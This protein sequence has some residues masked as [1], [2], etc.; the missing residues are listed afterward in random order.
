[1]FGSTIID[2]G[3]KTTTKVSCQFYDLVVTNQG[4][5]CLKSF[6]SLRELNFIC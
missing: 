5:L 4:Q 2:C 3:M 6:G 1:M